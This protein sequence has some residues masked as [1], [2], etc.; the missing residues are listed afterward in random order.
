MSSDLAWKPIVPIEGYLPDKLKN[1]LRRRY[2]DSLTNGV[3]FSNDSIGYLEGLM[4]VGVD[5][6]KELI[7]LLQTYG[8]IVVFEEH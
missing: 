1:V 6:A 2:G 3:T 4:D 5:G 7:E 8:E